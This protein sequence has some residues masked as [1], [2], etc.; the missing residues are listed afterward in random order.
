M[1][2]GSFEALKGITNPEENAK[3]L[4]HLQDVFGKIVRESRAKILFQEL[5]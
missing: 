1:P 5:S 2:A 3:L 4:R